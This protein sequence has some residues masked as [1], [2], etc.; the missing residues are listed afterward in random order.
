MGV[1]GPYRGRA[2]KLWIL[3][4]PNPRS[5]HAPGEKATRV[6]GSR[7]LVVNL[8]PVGGKW[9]AHQVDQ[10]A[11]AVPCKQFTFFSALGVLQGG[12]FC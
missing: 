3:T 8:L 1:T 2:T 12:R 9:W 11:I 5:L 6:K 10:V 7:P 4:L